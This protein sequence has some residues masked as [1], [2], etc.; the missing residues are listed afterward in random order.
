M[1]NLFPQSRQTLPSRQAESGMTRAV[2]ADASQISAAEFARSLG[3]RVRSAEQKQAE[4]D[5][6]VERYVKMILSGREF[7]EYGN[8][9]VREALRLIALREG[10]AEPTSDPLLKRRAA[11]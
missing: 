5:A 11:A 3:L 2:I 9:A 10:D 4:W 8:N 1:S 7:S 6:E